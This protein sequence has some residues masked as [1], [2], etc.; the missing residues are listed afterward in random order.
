MDP[1]PIKRQK[2]Y[3]QPALITAG[4]VIVGLSLILACFTAVLPPNNF[5][6]G[7]VTIPPGSTV[8]EST[9][10]LYA[11]HIIR[12]PKLF[13]LFFEYSHN[14][15]ILSG[16][17]SFSS[18]QTLRTVFVRITHGYFGVRE[19][20]VTLPEG[21]TRVQIATLLSQSL[22]QFSSEEF[23]AHTQEGYLFPDTYQFSSR[24]RATDVIQKL[25]DTWTKKITPLITD[26]HT[27]YST[28]EI[29]TLA[30]I[31][32][33]E[34]RGS[35]DRALIAG[36]LEKRLAKHMPLQVDASVAY[37]LGIDGKSLSKESLQIDTPYNTYLHRGL[38]TL[39]LSR[40]Q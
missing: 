4:I 25:Q 6:P 27:T 2:K 14:P 17:Y 33:K 15:V 39:A 36:I 23:L 11:N 32:E 35:D 8:K 3:S 5:T 13:E 40:P 19:I 26:N 7:Y 38:P 1:L 16:E 37:G 22:P 34:A 28:A 29:I 20:R 31:V 24:A 18:P 9:D 30:S 12:S 10:I 21:L